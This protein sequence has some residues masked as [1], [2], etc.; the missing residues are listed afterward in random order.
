M[1][2]AIIRDPKMNPRE[3][4]FG[5][6]FIHDLGGNFIYDKK[7][8]FNRNL[9]AGSIVNFEASTDSPIEYYPTERIIDGMHIIGKIK[10]IE[11]T[12]ITDA[13]NAPVINFLKNNGSNMLND[14]ELNKLMKGNT[15]IT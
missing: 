6:A 12:D 15:E 14:E 9:V 13:S 7:R 3:K 11:F 1:P 10:N 4:S 2:T 8:N 5:I